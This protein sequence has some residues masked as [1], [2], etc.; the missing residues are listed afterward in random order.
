MGIAEIA[1]ALEMSRPTTHRYASTLVALNYLEQGPGRKYRLGMRAGDP[2]RSAVSCTSLR[3]LPHRFIA[4][5]RDESS[6]TA[7]IAVLHGRD[8]VY[9]D[10]A[11]SAWQGQSEV[12]ARLGRG[13]RV[14]ARGTAMGRALLAQLSERERHE[15][16]EASASSTG[17]EEGVAT[18][19]LMSELERVSEKGFAIA[20]QVH[21]R[22]Q[23]CVAAPIRSRLGDAVGAVDVAAPKSRFSR[24]R[25]REELAPLVVASA[26]EMSKHLGFA[27]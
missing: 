10:R 18:D 13:S 24:A 22:G 9:V 14:P 3:N 26:A 20:D 27:P 12:A 11:R 6:C 7:S 21:V 16:V 1:D 25:A 5:L 2:G 4:E 19:K 8:I 17:G 23:L 15:A